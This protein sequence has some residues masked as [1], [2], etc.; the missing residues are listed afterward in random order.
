ML[1]MF[2]NISKL[3]NFPSSGLL[4]DIKQLYE[5]QVLKNSR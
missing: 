5:I 1:A 4:L 3:T 2:N